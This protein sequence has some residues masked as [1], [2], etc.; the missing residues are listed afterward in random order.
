MLTGAFS[1]KMYKVWGVTYPL[2]SVHRFASIPFDDIPHK[3]K[4]FFDS[5]YL[6]M[7][8]V[9]SPTI[10]RTGDGHSGFVS[11]HFFFLFLHVRHPVLVRP[12]FDNFVSGDIGG[13]FRGRPRLLLIGG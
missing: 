1:W 9:E 2:P 3:Y 4:S 7:Q 13:F 12:V 10:S 8:S 5:Y 11:S 6:Q